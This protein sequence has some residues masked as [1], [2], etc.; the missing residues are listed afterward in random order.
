[1]KTSLKSQNKTFSFPTDESSKYDQSMLDLK[2]MQMFLDI[3]ETTHSLNL[4][5]TV[6]SDWPCT[7]FPLPHHAYHGTQVQI[8][9]AF[10]H[11]YLLVEQKSC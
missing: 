10:I 1:M 8:S 11:V 3:L 4:F 6:D 9:T 2:L 7:P 5:Q